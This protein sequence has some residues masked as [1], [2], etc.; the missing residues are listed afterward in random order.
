MRVCESSGRYPTFI[1]RFLAMVTFSGLAMQFPTEVPLN[2][3]LKADDLPNF[4]PERAIFQFLPS[5]QHF[6]Q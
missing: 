6:N 4:I 3:P 5:K 2:S 1:F